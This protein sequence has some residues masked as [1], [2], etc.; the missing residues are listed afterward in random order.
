MKR[1]GDPTGTTEP[2]A[3]ERGTIVVY[4]DLSCAFAHLC[5]H[6]LHEARRRLGA[7][8]RVEHRPFLLEEVNEFPIPKHFLDSEVPQIA[9]LDIDAGWKVW[10]ELPE[11][12]P[13]STLL[14][15]EAVRAAAS[16]SPEAHEELDRALRVAFFR[17]HR[18][19]T[20]R[21]VILAVADEVPAVDADALAAALDDGTARGP[22]M[23]DAKDALG[24]VQGSPQFF[25]PDGST[26]H[27]PG[28]SVEW[29][30]EQGTGYPT[31]SF[32]GP[33]VYD[34]LVRR[35]R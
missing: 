4:S 32:E 26:V 28:I 20:M 35:S 24:F 25:L 15:M 19:I 27:A 6:Q 34:D 33:H 17:D 22:L 2:L 13:V 29:S 31:V 14:A 7:D 18:C 3:V 21:H 16:Q 5:I 11:R 1:D 12:W 30:G 8:L 9:P 23:H 10:D